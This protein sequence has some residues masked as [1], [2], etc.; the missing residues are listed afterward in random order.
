[1]NLKNLIQYLYKNTSVT[2]TEEKNFPE[3]HFSSLPNDSLVSQYWNPKI[4]NM[5]C[6]QSSLNRTKILK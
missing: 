2:R 3:V 6:I 5:E 1:M 4:N